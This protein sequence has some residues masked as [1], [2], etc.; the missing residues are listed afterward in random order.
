MPFSQL[1]G[2]S[3]SSAIKHLDIRLANSIVVFRGSTEDAAGQELKGKLV[4][5]LTEPIS[6]RRVSLTFKGNYQVGLVDGKLANQVGAKPIYSSAKHCFH[7]DTLDFFGSAD[8]DPFEKLPAG[9]YEYDFQF[10]LPGTLPESVEGV[11]WTGNIYGL[12]ATIETKGRYVKDVHTKKHVRVVRTLGPNALELSHVMAVDNTWTDKVKY[13]FT[14]PSKAAI[15]G[16]SIPSHI[17]L[18]PL[19]KGLRPHKIHYTIEEVQSL[20]LVPGGRYREYRRDVYKHDFECPIDLESSLDEEGEDCFVFVHSHQLPISLSECLQDASVHGCIKIRHR[21]KFAIELFNPDSHISE[22]K[23]LL[24]IQIYISPNYS[25]SGS[26][27]IQNTRPLAPSSILLDAPPSYNDHIFDQLYSGLSTPPFTPSATRPPSA[28]Q[29]PSRSRTPSSD[30]LTSLQM[31]PTSDGPDSIMLSQRLTTLSLTESVRRG[32]AQ[33]RLEALVEGSSTP[34]P[35]PPTR[36]TARTQSHTPAL[37]A[38]GVSSRS[39]SSLS[40]YLVPTASQLEQRDSRA[41]S[42]SSSVREARAS[43]IGSNAGAGSTLE[44]PDFIHIE[45]YDIGAMSRVPSYDTALS[46]RANTWIEVDLPDYSSATHTE[47]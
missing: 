47:E 46:S 21:L 37:V 14:T 7:E 9:N 6:V 38:G 30:N 3:N 1:F 17:K 12:K 45:T 22:L 5:C 42:I 27:T 40:G 29:T 43:S 20:A 18:I 15:L 32:S 35:L 34:A 44:T 8:A 13:S 33:P 19:L 39:T 16:G 11:P 25:I 2:G 28:T 24:P 41:S 36:Q 26:N 4:F 31:T 10:V 23:V